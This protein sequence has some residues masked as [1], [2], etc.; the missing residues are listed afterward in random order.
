MGMLEDDVDTGEAATNDEITDLLLRHERTN[1][2]KLVIP[3]DDSDS[4]DKDVRMGV[5][6]SIL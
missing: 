1:K 4:E 2:D 3:G 5:T 6:S